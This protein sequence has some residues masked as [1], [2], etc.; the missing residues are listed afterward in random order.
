[1]RYLLDTNALVFMLSAP[2]ELSE[3]A[4]Q[5]IRNAPDIS[6]SITSLWEI[7]IKQSLGKLRLE[8]D[9]PGIESQ[10][11]DRD[12]RVIPILSPAIERLKTLP[13][14]HRDP[15]DR[16]LIAQ[17]LEA[18]MVIVTCDATIP[19]YPVQTLW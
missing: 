5:V 17:A 6:V 13:P 4:E 9:I 16:L 18:G 11:I 1:M 15:F 2:Q 12:I 10:C 14:I 3:K 8:L 19:K 7:G